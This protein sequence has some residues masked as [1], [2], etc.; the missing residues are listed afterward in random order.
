MFPSEG[1][2]PKKKKKQSTTQSTSVQDTVKALRGK[3]EEEPPS[4]EKPPAQIILEAELDLAK[5][6]L[7]QQGEAAQYQKTYYS[8]STLTADVIRM[9]TGLPTKEVFQIVVN[10]AS[11]FKDS[12]SYYAG[13]KVES[14]LFEDQVF[15]TLMKL[16]QNYPNLHIAQLLSCSVGTISNVVTTF[17]HVLHS[18][19]YDDLMTTIPSREKNKL[20][21]PSSF[22]MFSSRRIVIDCTDIEIAAPGLMSL[23]NATYSNYRGMSSFKV[24]VEVAPNAVITYVSKLYPGSISDKEIVKQ[25]GLLNHMAS[26]DLILADKGFFN[27]GHCPKR[28]FCKHSSLFTEWKIHSK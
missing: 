2:P 6:E 12:L 7:K 23:Q 18:I 24:L 11:R 13:W 22:S 26:G 14:I 1:S 21:S 3:E 20:C 25:S 28:C 15:I 9:E 19:L 4:Q 5:R 16:R 10:Y 8:A 17:I 27:P